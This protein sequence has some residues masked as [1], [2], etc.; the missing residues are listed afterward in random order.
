MRLVAAFCD[1]RNSHQ[2]VLVIRGGKRLIR[3]LKYGWENMTK[4]GAGSE[5]GDFRQ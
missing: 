2:K 1:T 3:R 4:Q 5:A